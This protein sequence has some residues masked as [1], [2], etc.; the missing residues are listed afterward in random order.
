MGY[1]MHFRS[2]HVFSIELYVARETR[3]LEKVPNL[4]ECWEFPY[5]CA[6]ASALEKNNHQLLRWQEYKVIESPKTPRVPPKT[7][8]SLAT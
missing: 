4:P 8:P 6:T 5:N 2:L 7:S 3:C 1:R